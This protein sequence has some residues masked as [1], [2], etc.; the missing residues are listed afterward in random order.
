MDHIHQPPWTSRPRPAR[1]GTGRSHSFG[2]IVKMLFSEVGSRTGTPRE[3]RMNG[4]A[5]LGDIPHRRS[6]PSASPSH[7][8]ACPHCGQAKV[9]AFHDD[10]RRP[11]CA[12]CTGNDPIYACPRC[13]R[14]DR[15]YGH[16]C[17]VCTPQDRAT[18]LLAGPSGHIHPRLQPVFG[19]WMAGKDPR[20]T[21]QWIRKRSS[22]P[23]ILRAM[24]L[25]ELPISH[26]TFDDL[27][28]TRPV[29]YVRDLLTATGVLEPYQ[30]LI[31]RTMPWLGEVP[32]YIDYE[33]KS[34]ML[35]A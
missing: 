18:A 28:G 13:G 16:L 30:P 24:A 31:A 22:S 4:I 1:D 14:E 15:P 8:Q 32:I 19:A 2:R 34:A 6:Y 23:E 20:S 3:R 33:Y 5:A 26:T 7:G 11:A 27:P 29:N 35:R 21:L 10:Q 25:G 12:S 9:L 17:S